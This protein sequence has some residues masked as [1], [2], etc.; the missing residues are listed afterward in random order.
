[1]LTNYTCQCCGGEFQSERSIEDADE[2]S[3]ALFG[4]DHKDPNA[5][6]I[7]EPCWVDLLVEFAPDA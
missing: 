2:E 1:M 6:I 5:A 3:I 4:M 7:C